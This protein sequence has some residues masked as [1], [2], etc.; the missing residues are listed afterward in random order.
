MGGKEDVRLGAVRRVFEV[1]A[2]E[3]SKKI[4][5]A[6]FRN[7]LSVEKLEGRARIWVVRRRL[8]RGE[9]SEPVKVGTATGCLFLEGG[10]KKA[11]KGSETS[12]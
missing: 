4:M 7:S 10:S 8:V 12:I 9:I 1:E 6:E 2:L 3:G 11:K 5:A